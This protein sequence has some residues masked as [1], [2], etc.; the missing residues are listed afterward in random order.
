MRRRCDDPTDRAYPRYGGRGIFV[1]SEW[2]AFEQFLID[3]GE[4]PSGTTIERRDGSKGYTKDNCVWA[5]TTEQNRNRRGVHR[6]TLCGLS[7]AVT[8][9][10]ELYGLKYQRVANRFVR[11]RIS[12]TEA[13]PGSFA[14]R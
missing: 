11:H 7:M 6:I 5:T 9:A 13:F 12:R 10:C 4:R 2:Q 1:C 8:A 3:M 14:D